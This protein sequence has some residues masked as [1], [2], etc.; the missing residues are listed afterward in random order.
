MTPVLLINGLYSLPNLNTEALF[1]YAGSYFQRS[2]PFL[3]LEWQ[4]LILS[5]LFLF[6]VKIV[7]FPHKEKIQ[8]SQNDRMA[9]DTFNILDLS[10]IINYEQNIPFYYFYLTRYKSL[11]AF[12][13]Y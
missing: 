2:T 11:G 4:Y 8:C 7:R 1:R 5:I 12:S 9:L 6:G 10:L 13:L 3:S